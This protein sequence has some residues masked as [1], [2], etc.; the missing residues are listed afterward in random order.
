MSEV[1]IDP[2]RTS[3]GHM[4]ILTDVTRCI[5][6]EECVVACQR[7]NDTGEEAPYRWQRGALELSSN[8]WTTIKRGP[9]GRF[10]REHCRHCLDPACAA[11]CPVGAL[12]KS[13]Q[14][15]VIYDPDI[16][17]GCRYCM[18]ACPFRMTR[19]EWESATPRVRKCILCHDRVAGG[20]LE[21]PACTAAC[22][23]GA[24]VYGDREALLAEARRRIAAEPDRYVDHIWGE[25]EVGGTSVLYL[26][27][28]DLSTVGWP[29]FLD[30]RPVP[31]LAR[32]VLHTVPWTFGSV[33]VAMF[34]IQWIT[35]RRQEVARAEAGDVAE[36]T[37][38]NGDDQVETDEGGAR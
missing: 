25:H 23:T 13:T 11:A 18:M 5:G 20:T 15:P 27:D 6:C 8:R 38:A 7:T 22:P 1:F 9:R 28:V 4:A 37:H 17:M 12:Q 14:G 3:I 26:S 21:Q 30:D 19:Y 36:A 10:V 24:T 16:C 2:G 33:A 35:K 34:G 29:P 31:T 32:R